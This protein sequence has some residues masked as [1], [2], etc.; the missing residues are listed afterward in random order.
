[1]L[2]G[3]NQMVANQGLLPSGNYGGGGGGY[4]WTSI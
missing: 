3:V 2:R 4:D 1:M